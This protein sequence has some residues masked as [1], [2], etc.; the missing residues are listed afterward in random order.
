[1]IRRLTMIHLRYG[2]TVFG[3]ATALATGACANGKSTASTGDGGDDVT[4][5]GNG[6]GDEPPGD[7]TITP[8]VQPGNPANEADE[9]APAIP[10]DAAPV[11]ADAGTG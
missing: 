2:V 5:S 1:M 9:G 7:A 11:V 6:E 3:L 4:I 10:D 8:P